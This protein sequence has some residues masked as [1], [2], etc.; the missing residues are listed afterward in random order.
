MKAK[1]ADDRRLKPAHRFVDIGPPP[2]IAF[3]YKPRVVHRD[4][5]AEWAKAFELAGKDFGGPLDAQQFALM[6]QIVEMATKPATKPRALPMARPMIMV[7][8]E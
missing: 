3:D 8:A 5:E 4:V 6:R 7:A 1:R 2:A